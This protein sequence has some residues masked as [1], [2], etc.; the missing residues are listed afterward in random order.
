MDGGLIDY[1]RLQITPLSALSLLYLLKVVPSTAH[2]ALNFAA[3]RYNQ[4]PTALS[5]PREKPAQTLSRRGN[6][7][8]HVCR[9][10]RVFTSAHIPRARKN[11]CV[12]DFNNRYTVT[13]IREKP[14]AH[15]RRYYADRSCNAVTFVTRRYHL[16]PPSSLPPI[17]LTSGTK[18]R[19]DFFPR[20][21]RTAIRYKLRATPELI[22]RVINSRAIAP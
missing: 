18:F 21:A 8:I 7:V 15:A 20:P 2:F 17:T 12:S 11:P 13:R 10:T 16:T 6:Q 19:H 1:A 3:A 22:I 14:R 5:A 4:P 9:R